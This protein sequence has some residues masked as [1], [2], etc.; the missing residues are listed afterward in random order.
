MVRMEKK[1]RKTIMETDG[2]RIVITILKETK[3]IGVE[4]AL[5]SVEVGGWPFHEVRVG[6]IGGPTKIRFLTD[7]VGLDD[8]L[9][10]VGEFD[11][12]NV[13]EYDVYI[14]SDYFVAEDKF[15]TFVDETPAMRSLLFVYNEEE[16]EGRWV[17]GATL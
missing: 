8:L 13:M 14:F 5:N 1:T 10:D 4:I 12:E 6:P 9:M 17:M 7:G 3:M 16:G 11:P 15:K 2:E